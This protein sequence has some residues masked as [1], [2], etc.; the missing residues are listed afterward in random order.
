[1][2]TVRLLAAEIAWLSNVRMKTS[3]I[4]KESLMGCLVCI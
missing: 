1:M 4:L 2:I 3:K